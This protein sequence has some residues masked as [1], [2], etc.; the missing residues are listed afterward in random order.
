MVDLAIYLAAP[1]FNERE[2][3]FNGYLAGL[4][5]PFA[6]VY[7]PQRD[8]SLLTE[9]VAAGVPLVVAEKR[10]FKQD[11][12]ALRRCNVIVAVLDG[13]HIDEGVA[14]EIGF[15]RATECL[16]VGLQSDSRRALPT[17]NNPM[18]QCSL[19]A[20]FSDT[21]SLVNFLADQAYKKRA[22]RSSAVP[23]F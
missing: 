2:R 17:G 19:D 1:L 4:F 5:A 21:S 16:C 3:E 10:V 18:I 23:S 8:G 15:S 12:D 7:L 9:M 22:G 14:F 20:I 11:C 6:E 13:A